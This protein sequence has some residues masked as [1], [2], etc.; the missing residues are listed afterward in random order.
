MT[1]GQREGELFGLVVTF[2]ADMIP[3]AIEVHGDASDLPPRPTGWAMMDNQ[4][5]FAWLHQQPGLTFLVGEGSTEEMFSQ[6]GFLV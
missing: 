4:S 6:Q 3:G 1:E 2:D 5:R